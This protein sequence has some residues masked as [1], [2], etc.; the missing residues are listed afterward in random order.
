MLNFPRCTKS[1]AESTYSAYGITPAAQARIVS[2]KREDKTTELQTLNILDMRVPRTECYAPFPWRVL[3]AVD[4]EV[5][6]GL[7]Y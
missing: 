4:F 5:T 2:A 6:R 7:G 3:A 1:P